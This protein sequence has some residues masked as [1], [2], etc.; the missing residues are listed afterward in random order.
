MMTYQVVAPVAVRPLWSGRVIV[1]AVGL[2]AIALVSVECALPLRWA[3]AF[4]T[5]VADRAAAMPS[6]A[7]A[8]A[9]RRRSS[10]LFCSSLSRDIGSEAEVSLG[11]FGVS[12][13]QATPRAG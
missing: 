4:A 7:R 1:S 6:R 12:G 11:G 5:T 9:E 10:S 8:D 2:R 13:G 3:P